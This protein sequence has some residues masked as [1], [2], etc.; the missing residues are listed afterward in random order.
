MSRG[1]DL[2]LAM[3]AAKA[4][5]DALAGRG[6]AFQGVDSEIGRDIKLKADKAA[7]AIIL[8]ILK[9]GSDHV[10]LAEESGWVGAASDTAWVVDPLDGSS[11]YIREIPVCAV[12]IGLI[13]NGKPTIGVIHDFNM[14]EVYAGAIGEGAAL[15]GAPMRVSDIEELHRGTLMTGLPFGKREFTD[16]EFI[17]MGKEHQRWK[18]V[19]MIGSAALS[20]AYIAAGRAERYEETAM[21]WDIAAGCALV[22]AA[23]GRVEIGDGP[24]D[25]PLTVF[26]DNGKLPR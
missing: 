17:A 3:K 4:A 19:R 14:D 16:E 12:S 1:N 15:N 23:G 20:G 9:S 18:K 2:E 8:D 21:L 26:A 6:E 22:E 11:N 10:V 24:L 13:E 7:E 5:G 25:G